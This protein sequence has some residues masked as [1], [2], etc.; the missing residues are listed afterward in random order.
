MSVPDLESRLRSYYER[1]QPDDSMHLALASHKLLDDARQPHGRRPSWRILRLAALMAGAVVAL[2]ILVMPRF[3]GLVG[4]ASGPG[5]SGPTFNLPAALDAQVDEAGLMRAGGIWA[6]QGSYLLTS[7][8]NGA[9]WRAG[10]F[11]SPGGPVPVEEVFVLDP[12]HAWA[13]TANGMNGGVSPA[14]A[15]QVLT[16]NRTGDGGQTWQ[17]T[18]VSG[19]Y[20]CQLASLSFVDAD[21]GF[22]MCAV[23]STPGPSGPTAQSLTQAVAGSGIV[24]RTDDGGASWLVAGGATGLGSQFTA[25]DATTLWSVPDSVASMLTGARLYV[26]RNAGLTWS[27]VDLPGL[28]PLDPNTQ[29][30][31]RDGPVF[32]DASHGSFA[33]SVC[34]SSNSAAVWFF[35][36][37][38]GGKSWSAFKK[39]QQATAAFPI[40]A[41][42]GKVWAVVGDSGLW[43]MS[44]SADSGATWT[45]VP[46]YGMPD[47]TTF[48]SLDLIDKDH[49][50]ATVFGVQGTRSLMLTSDGGQTWHA[51]DFGDA[52]ARVSSTSADPVAATNMAS[53]FETMAVKDP[54]TA[55]NMLSSYSQGAF[56]SES[57]FG[58]AETALGV[59]TNYAPYQL[60]LPTQSADLLSRQHLGPAAWGDLTSFADMSRAYVI[61]ASFPGTSEPSQ[62]LVVAPLAI[63]GDWRVWVVTMP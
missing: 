44:V 59:R 3:G 9:T 24:L 31:E 54:P 51:A 61:V 49:S 47:N 17:S 35:Q 15:G 4:P 43:S 20:G 23:A 29:I 37:A 48:L 60:G 53:N 19:D 18:T 63:T 62:T 16:V 50:L 36:T 41:V 22:I 58:A 21:R 55:W 32:W 45:A 1:F 40:T 2:A 57:A 46:G 5:S 6:V 11:P 52:R 27:A 25:S 42:V 13:I 30:D 38:D 56:R 10:T 14:I 8:D 39:P 7:T 12:D 33:V 34:C 26:S 28:P